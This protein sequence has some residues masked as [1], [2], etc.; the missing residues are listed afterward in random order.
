MQT[1]LGGANRPWDKY[2]SVWAK[3]PVGNDN[4]EPT[5][6]KTNNTPFYIQIK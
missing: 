1:H 2:S 4:D 3:R 6:N 5:N